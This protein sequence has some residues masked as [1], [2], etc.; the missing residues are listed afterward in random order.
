MIRIFVINIIRFFL[1]VLFQVLFLK[2]FSLYNLAIP[3]FYVL[4]IL[5]LPLQTSNFLLFLLSFLLGLSVDMFSNS[6][7]L[8][9]AACTVMAFCRILL[10]RV[11]T[12][13]DGYENTAEPG[14][15]AMG[16][17]WFLMYS[18]V[19]VIIHH[20]VLFNLEIFRL[21]EFLLSSAKAVSSAIFTLFLIILSQYLFSGKRK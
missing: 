5:L 21:Q 13:R 18:S 15:R 16:L 19:L 1:L 17:R 2:N 4:F 10:I 3:W 14:I 8:H 7:G 20:L 6:P 12:P 11:I 9:A